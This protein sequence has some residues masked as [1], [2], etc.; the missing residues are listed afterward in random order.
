MRTGAKVY[1]I[2]VK[3]PGIPYLIIQVTF[4]L[5]KKIFHPAIWLISLLVWMGGLAGGGVDNLMIKIIQLRLS[6]RLALFFIQ[7]KNKYSFSTTCFNYGKWVTEKR[8]EMSKF[9]SLYG[10]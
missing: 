4:C 8:A 7:T 9:I 6:L 1:Y 3:A 2:E 5:L 10:S